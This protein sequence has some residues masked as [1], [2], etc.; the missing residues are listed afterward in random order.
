MSL[1]LCGPYVTVSCFRDFRVFVVTLFAQARNVKRA[2]ERLSILHEDDEILVI[3]KPAG[4]LTIPSLPTRAAFEDTVL[5]RV[6][7][8]VAKPRGPRP[9]VGVLHRLDRD[10]SGALA[11]ALTREAHAIG[12]ELF[13]SH[14]FE[15][16]YLA[17]VH[18]VPYPLR[19]SIDVPISDRYVAGKRGV[20][21][22]G[23]PARGAITHYTV[24][25]A[26]GRASLL[27]LE[28]ETGRQH[29]IRVH[30]E[31]LGYPLV[32]ERVYGA[33][34]SKLRAPRQMLHAWKLVF[35]HPV[36]HRTITAE[37][38][39]PPDFLELIARLDRTFR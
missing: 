3:D 10:T 20:A 15:R 22:A 29:Q 2:R 32:G 5:R 27:E 11:L 28:L 25:R 31:H 34:T 4:L 1:C 39:P 8:Y 13:R 9:Y 18:G 7:D 12:R 14:R 26:F 30:L 17:I 6:R 16:R 37:A 24:L 21:R 35:P 23:Q 38:D 19:G 36:R 33:T